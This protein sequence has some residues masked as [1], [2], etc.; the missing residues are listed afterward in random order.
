MKKGLVLLFVFIAVVGFVFAS[1]STEGSSSGTKVLKLGCTS[2][3]GSVHQTGA[4][5]FQKYLREVSGGKLDVTLHMGGA[6]GTTAQEYAQLKTGDLDMYLTAFD[7]ACVL[8]D[9]GDFMVTCVPFIFDDF[10]HYLRFVNSDLCKSMIEKVEKTNG[11]H[12]LG[13]L[14]PSLPRAC[15]TVNKPIASVEDVKGIKMRVPETQ[16]IFEMWKAWGASPVITPGSQ[17][18]SAM[19]SGLVDGQDNDVISTNSNNYQEIT[20]YYT[21]INYIQQ[22]LV[23]WYSQTL[24]DKLSAQEKAWIEQARDLAYKEHE[25]WLDGAYAEAKAKMIADGMTFVEPDIDSF[26]KATDEAIVAFDGVLWT[27]G[28]YNQIRAL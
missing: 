27:K 28:L 9:G 8:A 22:S 18:Y 7:T 17:T 19:E 15:N 12:F 3:V 5:R 23:V 1:G 14:F 21:E 10:D 26:Q 13:M 25:E 4:E 24:W 16:A 2:P 20:K 6:L 11:V